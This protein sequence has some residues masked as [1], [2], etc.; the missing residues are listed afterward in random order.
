MERVWRDL[1]D[2]ARVKEGRRGWVPAMG[3]GSGPNGRTARLGGWDGNALLGAVS[4]TGCRLDSHRTSRVST[5]K[6]SSDLKENVSFHHIN[7]FGSHTRLVFP[8]QKPVRTL[9]RTSC[10]ALTKAS[11]DL[12][13]NGF[14]FHHKNY[15]GPHR[16]SCASTTKNPVWT[17]IRKTNRRRLRKEL[18]AVN[19]KNLMECTT[20]VVYAKCSAKLGGV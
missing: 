3:R 12:T 13:Q 6:A 20:N 8:P 14:S 10:V 19:R 16:E 15:F 17:S 2:A 7:H 4:L 1:G 18:M 9:H 11:S 5:T